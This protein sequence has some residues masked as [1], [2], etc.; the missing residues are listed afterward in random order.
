MKGK[1]AI[2]VALVA[3]ITCWTGASAGSFAP[4]PVLGNTVLDFDTQSG[5]YS[6]WVI[7]DIGSIN[8]VHATLQIHRLG[9]D[10]KWAPSFSIIISNGDSRVAFKI[11]ALP[12]ESSL[13]MQLARSA[14]ENSDDPQLL[15]TLGLNQAVDVAIEWTADG[16][17]TVTAGKETRTAVLG[18]PAKALEFV[19]STGEVE[20]NPLQIGTSTP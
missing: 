10:P 1:L 4:L 16:T 18:A 15:G 2:I 19:G 9:S 5:S 7:S 11:L 6:G 20:F 17:V 12:G 8:A 13:I 14:K 3:T